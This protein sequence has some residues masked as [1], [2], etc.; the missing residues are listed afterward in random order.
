MTQGT[1]DIIFDG[2][3]LTE[4]GCVI[5]DPPKRPFPKRKYEKLSVYG[6]SGDL[7][8]DEDA[9]DNLSLTYNVATV[10]GLYKDLFVDE[11]LTSLKVWLCSSV[12]Y[13]KLYDTE[14][15]DG[16]YYAFCSGISDAVCTFDDMYE[17]SVTFDCKPFFYFDS[18]QETVQTTNKNIRLYNIGTRTAK[19]MIRIYGSG[20]LGCYINGTR[21]IVNNVGTDVIVDSES[22][23]V[24][25]GAVNKYDDFE[26]KYPDLAV[27]NN[28]FSFTGD[29]FQSARIIPRWCRL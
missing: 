28:T 5:T 14:L 6:R 21:F 1:Q 8:V 9:Y 27:G 23:L 2:H 15:P 22:M 11:V 16:F 24:Y 29:G 13:K 18:G 7:I 20:T 3:S 17:F 4:Y 25:S 10:P 19:P 26:G 12:L